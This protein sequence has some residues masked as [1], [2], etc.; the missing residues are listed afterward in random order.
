MGARG[1]F[2]IQILR[3]SRIR[4]LKPILGMSFNPENSLILNILML[5]IYFSAPPYTHYKDIPQND[6]RY[7]LE[8]PLAQ[9]DQ[10]M[11]RSVCQY[12]YAVYRSAHMRKNRTLNSRLL[13]IK[14]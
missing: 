1:E 10:N 6:Q 7:I 12:R 8:S 13:G 2:D 14:S 9:A 4:K 11:D 5:T 3:M